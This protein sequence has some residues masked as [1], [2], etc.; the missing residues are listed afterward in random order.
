[1]YGKCVYYPKSHVLLEGELLNDCGKGES[2]EGGYECMLPPR[3]TY[4][5]VE[6]KKRGKAELNDCTL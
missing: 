5:S 6:K 4:Q 2:G 3:D 1:M